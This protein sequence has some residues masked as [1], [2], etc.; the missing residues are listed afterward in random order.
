[1]IKKKTFGQSVLDF[2]QRFDPEQ[3]SKKIQKS[4]EKTSREA[5]KVPM[6]EEEERRTEYLFNFVF[7][8]SFFVFIYLMYKILF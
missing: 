4:L 5:A 3:L 6:T 8:S 1:M 2:L 7:A